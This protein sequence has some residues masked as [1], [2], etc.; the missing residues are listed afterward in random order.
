VSQ[1]DSLLPP[2]APGLD[3]PL[4]MLHACHGRVRDQ[5]GTLI[6]LA[7]WLPQHAA[8]EPARRAARAVMR[9]FDLAAVHHHRDEEEDLLPAM[10][11]AVGAEGRER[12]AALDARLRREHAELESAWRVLRE[13]LARIAGGEA[14]PLDAGRVRDFADAYETHI[15]LEEDALLPWAARVL[16]EAAVAAMSRAM[17]ARRTVTAPAD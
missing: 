10:R 5:L 15:R 1:G 2:P 11:E 6:R 9:Y 4:E 14:A 3:E 17:T 7:D 13:P 12:L 8:D 16:G